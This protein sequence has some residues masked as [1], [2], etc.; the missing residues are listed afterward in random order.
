MIR[1]TPARNAGLLAVSLLVWAAVTYARAAGVTVPSTGATWPPPS[2]GGIIGPLDEPT[3]TG[4]HHSLPDN[5]RGMMALSFSGGNTYTPGVLKRVTIT[6]TPSAFSPNQVKYGFQAT[7][8]LFNNARAGH[9]LNG[10]TGSPQSLRCAATRTGTL[11]NRF[12]GCEPGEV[13]IIQHVEP[14]TGQGSSSY[15]LSFLWEPPASNAGDVA[16][17]ATSVLAVT[18]ITGA[19]APYR[20]KATLTYEAPATS[21]D[22]AYLVGTL[23]LETWDRPSNRIVSTSRVFNNVPLFKAAMTRDGSRLYALAANNFGTTL[24]TFDPRTGTQMNALSGGWGSIA[25]SPDE[26]RLY[27]APNSAIGGVDVF[28][29]RTGAIIDHFDVGIPDSDVLAVSPDNKRVYVLKPSFGPIIAVDAATLVEQ[30]TFTTPSAS[31]PVAMAVSP[32][33]SRLYVTDADGYLTIFST[34]TTA[35]VDRY[36][37]APTPG[38]IVFSPDGSRAYVLSTGGPQVVTTID[39]ASS[40]ALGAVPLTGYQGSSAFFHISRDGTHLYGG[41]DAV[42]FDWSARAWALPI[43]PA[44]APVPIPSAQ[45]VL[46][47]AIPPP[48]VKADP[49]TNVTGIPG[50]AQVVL[51]WTPPATNGGAAITGYRVQVATTVGG[52]Y[53][54]AAG[55]LVSSPTPSCTATGLTNGTPHFFKV[56]AINVAGTGTYSAASPGLTP[57]TVPDPPTSIIGIP[58]NTQVALSWAPPVTSGGSAITGYRVQMATSAG[59]PYNDAGCP[60]TSTTPSCAVIGLVNRTTY[61][62]KVAAINSVGTGAYSSASSAVMPAMMFTDDPLQA[63]TFIKA[64]HV[65]ELRIRINAIR[66][67]FA[68]PPYPYMDP[69][70]GVGSTPI[71]A[72]H[73]L[74]LRLALAQ[75]Y[76]NAGRTQPAYSE[77]G[78]GPGVTMK[79]AHITE[80]RAAVIAIE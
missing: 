8:R 13:E 21:A 7:A 38:P 25:L 36:A 17:Y 46:D 35:I 29:A 56:A 69:S 50:N 78:L 31:L 70:L 1:P 27:A 41:A 68:L 75:A 57:A 4:C 37:L 30:A 6:I 42:G 76:V 9:I 44:G 74:D 33:S 15:S 12:A 67:R 40:I 79:A 19:T 66:S 54:D 53:G 73:I 11:I 62:F 39:V 5:S 23:G 2:P 43:N 77:P 52:P 45:G 18:P 14:Y 32:D 48:P 80:L 65:I 10:L 60:M 58:G 3:C 72:Q 61:Y 16:F 64:V 20:T 55:C 51:S 34:A 47:I 49:P 71:K 59:G 63:G 22:P 24:V 28:D 26:S